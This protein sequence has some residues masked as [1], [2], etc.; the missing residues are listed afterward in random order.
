MCKVTY[1]PS[2]D[3]R[4]SSADVGH[5]QKKS[6][7]CKKGQNITVNIWRTTEEVDFA[8]ILNT[9]RVSADFMFKVSGLETVMC[10]RS[11]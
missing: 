3:V 10:Y 7:I 1:P 6:F 5:K 8:A 11:I 2:G 4:G 9:K